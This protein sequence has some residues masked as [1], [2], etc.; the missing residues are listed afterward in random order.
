MGKCISLLRHDMMK[1]YNY[2]IFL[3]A[4]NLLIACTSGTKP[5]FKHSLHKY[6]KVA[7]GCASIDPKFRMVSNIIGER[8]TFQKCLPVSFKGSY[9]ADRK[10][11]SVIIAFEKADEATA[12]F[13]IILDINTQPRYN[14][15]IIDGNTFQIAPA[16]N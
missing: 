13:N 7:D 8:Y 6:E 3:F 11:D 15:L 14:Y 12:V 4:C 9:M 10:G 5:Y 1:S 16:G 2:I